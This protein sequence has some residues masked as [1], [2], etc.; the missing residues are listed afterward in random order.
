MPRPP[1]GPPMP[2]T[3][4][5]DLIDGR[6][7]APAAPTGTLE[8]RSPADLDDVVGEFPTST[9]HVGA[10]VAAARRAQAGGEAT[11]LDARIVLLR[12]FGEELR[13]REATLVELLGREVGKPAW[14]AKT[15]VAA[16]ISKIAI[17]IDEGLAFVRGFSLDGGKLECRFRPHGVLA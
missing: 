17:T 2:V 9:A 11:A 8:V 10:A 4:R 12:A 3:S 15:E 6:F 13:R 16:L 1:K 5:G 7:V 14:E